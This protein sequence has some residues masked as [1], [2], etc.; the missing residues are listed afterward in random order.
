MKLDVP[1]EPA[2]YRPGDLVTQIVPPNLP[3][4][5][6]VSDRASADA[7]RWSSTI[8]ARRAREEDRLFVYER[9]RRFRFG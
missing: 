6:I 4:I 7:R 2:A 1:D 3:H 9:K 8:S 5:V